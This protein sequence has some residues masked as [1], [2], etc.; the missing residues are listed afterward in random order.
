M[1]F[2]VWKDELAAAADA[3]VFHLAGE[4]SDVIDR[5][6]FLFPGLHIVA[7]ELGGTDMRGSIIHSKLIDWSTHL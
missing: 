2:G 4:A 1:F 7:I 6:D 3:I 5:L